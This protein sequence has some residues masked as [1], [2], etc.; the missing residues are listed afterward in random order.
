MTLEGSGPVPSRW[1]TCPSATEQWQ[2]SGHCSIV[3]AEFVT[4]ISS[5]D[6]LSGLIPVC[7]GRGRLYNTPVLREN[8]QW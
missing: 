6:R 3:R 8:P 5:S 4:L 1:P 7:R 2:G